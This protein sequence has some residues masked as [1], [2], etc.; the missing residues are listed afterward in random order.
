MKLNAQRI[1]RNR[2][3]QSHPQRT[4]ALRAQLDNNRQAGRALFE[5]A[6][7]I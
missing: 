6:P 7:A 1:L 4:I 3:L 2:R 5:L